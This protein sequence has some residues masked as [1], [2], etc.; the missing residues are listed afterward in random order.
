MTTREINM[1]KRIVP[2]ILLVL[3]AGQL[4]GCALMPSS[5]LVEL[6]D[7]GDNIAVEVIA[8]SSYKVQDILGQ[9]VD[10]FEWI[11]LDKLK[12]Y[13]EAF[14]LDFDDIFYTVIISENGE[15]GKNGCLFVGKDGKRNGNSTLED[16]LRNKVFQEK[17]WSKDETKRALRKIASEAYADID[18]SENGQYALMASINAYYNLLSDSVNPSA[19]N[20]TQ[21]VTREQ[22][23]SLLYRYNTPVSKDY[24]A[25]YAGITDP[26]TQQVGGETAHTAFAKQMDRYSFLKAADGSLDGNNSQGSITRLEAIYMVVQSQFS[27]ELEQVNPKEKVSYSDVKNGGDIALKQGFRIKNKDT[28][29]VEEKKN[30]ET[31][32]L[33][34][35][36]QN[37]DKGIQQELYN[38]IVIADKLGLMGVDE[39]N[40]IRWDEPI[41]RSESIE[42]LIKVAE[43]KN[44]L[45][46][47]L[48]ENEFGAMESKVVDNSSSSIPSNV[49]VPS[50]EDAASS[51]SSGSLPEKESVEAIAP[52]APKTQPQNSSSSKEQQIIDESKQNSSKPASKGPNGLII[53]DG[54]DGIKYEGE[55]GKTESGGGWN[56]SIYG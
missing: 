52:T 2:L 53:H 14:R 27:K 18:A 13:N 9:Q 12:T 10:T 30:W 36:L 39:E 8:P 15:G 19:F 21:S 6:I 7:S 43:A 26:Y 22:F 48:S 56:N 4:S 11:Q 17:Y 37:P 24:L 16:G 25:D 29:E 55:T 35:M 31:Y 23:A 38:A 33:Y 42:L 3:L 47:Y 5:D 51:S 44:K 32:T 1:V 50:V 20:P 41:S 45:Y 49:P 28:K 40:A 46:G 54:F 34:Y